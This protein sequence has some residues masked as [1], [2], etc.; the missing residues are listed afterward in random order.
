MLRK[1]KLHKVYSIGLDAKYAT[2]SPDSG[3]TTRSFDAADQLVGSVDAAGHRASY[4]HDAAGRI[5]EQTIT[6]AAN[7]TPAATAAASSP[8]P[9]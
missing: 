7:S 1:M 4:A 6:P 5:L 9:K 2:L 3:L 8:P